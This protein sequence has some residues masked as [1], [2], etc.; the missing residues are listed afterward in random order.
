MRDIVGRQSVALSLTVSFLGSA[1]H[2]NCHR[3]GSLHV[4][5]NGKMKSEPSEI[6]KHIETDALCSHFSNGL[7]SQP[8]APS[9][10]N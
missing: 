3:A 6:K 4:T 9:H 7:E 2:R 8:Y 5:A 10:P 1:H